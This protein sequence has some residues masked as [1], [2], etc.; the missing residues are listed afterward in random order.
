LIGALTA[1]LPQPAAPAACPA[2][3]TPDK[4]ASLDEQIAAILPTAEEDRFL[5]VPWRTNLMAARR[6]AQAAGK[7]GLP[8]DHGGEPQGCT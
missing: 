7:A 3:A 5:R 6:E 8:V 2:P 4:G 1:A